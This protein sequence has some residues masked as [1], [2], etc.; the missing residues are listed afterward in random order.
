MPLHLQATTGF[1]SQHFMFYTAGPLN[2]QDFD[3]ETRMLSFT[4]PA[5]VGA[6]SDTRS[7]TELQRS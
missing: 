2:T 5:G 6:T 7:P 1:Q 3:H 4:V